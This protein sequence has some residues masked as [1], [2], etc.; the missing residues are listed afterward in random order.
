[1]TEIQD[2]NKSGTLSRAIHDG[3][4]YTTFLLM[5]YVERD[6]RRRHELY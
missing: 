1:M 5:N 3:K 6:G 2:E 4:Y